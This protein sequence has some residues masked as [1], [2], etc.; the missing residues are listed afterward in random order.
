MWVFA[1]PPP[2]DAD[3]L[4]VCGASPQ[5]KGPGVGGTEFF[6]MTSFDVRPDEDIRVSLAGLPEMHEVKI[7]DPPWCPVWLWERGPTTN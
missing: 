3:F 1:G 4:P 2:C 5:E 6:C 7:P